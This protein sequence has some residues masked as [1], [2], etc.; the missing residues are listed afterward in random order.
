MTQPFPTEKPEW[1]NAEAEQNFSI[2]QPFIN[3]ARTAQALLNISSSQ[4]PF[5]YAMSN[6]DKVTKTLDSLKPYIESILRSSLETNN[7]LLPPRT[8]E[9]P[10]GNGITLGI[11]VPNQV[12]LQQVV[13]KIKKQRGEKEKEVQRVESR[14]SSQN[15][16]EKAEPSVIQESKD[17]RTKLD[18]ERVELYLAEQQLE[19]MLN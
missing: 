15:F 5:I 3:T 17:R 2:L 9:L 4:T 10:A 7:Q 18:D 14:L 1:A 19:S 12:D 11:Q 13:K 8:L 6:Q 16:M